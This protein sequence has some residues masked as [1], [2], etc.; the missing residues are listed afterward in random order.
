MPEDKSVKLTWLRGAQ[1][2]VME[3]VKSAFNCAGNLNARCITTTS[4]KSVLA[5]RVFIFMRL[6]YDTKVPVPQAAN[7]RHRHSF[8]QTKS[9]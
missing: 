6:V 2:L 7:F 1:P 3:E 4:G 8:Q 9:E 5:I